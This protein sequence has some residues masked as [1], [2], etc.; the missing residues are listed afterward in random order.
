MVETNMAQREQAAQYRVDVTAHLAEKMANATV[1][2]D[3][4]IALRSIPFVGQIGVR[5]VLNSASAKA[6]EGVLGLK[7]PER[8]GQTSHANGV[9]ALWMSPD[10]FLLVTDSANGAVVDAADHVAALA[11]ALGELPGSVIDLSSNRVVLELSGPSAKDLLD[12]GC[13]IDLHQ[14]V[15]PA[16]TAIQATLGRVPAFIWK[17]DDSTYYVLVRSSF[18]EHT[19]NWIIDAMLEYA[20]DKVA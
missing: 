16:G 17:R 6:L 4:G 11:A 19:I 15:F 1:S 2:G 3:R 9:F 8:V 13:A 18:A 10:E 14:S 12:K 5:A 20:A 7:L